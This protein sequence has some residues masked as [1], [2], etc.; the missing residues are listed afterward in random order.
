MDSVKHHGQGLAPRTESSVI[1][2]VHSGIV[3]QHHGQFPILLRLAGS[4]PSG[5]RTGPSPVSCILWGVTA[6]EPWTVILSCFALVFQLQHQ[7]QGFSARFRGWGSFLNCCSCTFYSIWTTPT[8]IN[9]LL[10]TFHPAPTH[11]APWY[12]IRRE[13]CSV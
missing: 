10:H 12:L 4:F 7:G 5:P 3:C 6:S 11:P 8:V 1:N 9:P 2:P 13:T